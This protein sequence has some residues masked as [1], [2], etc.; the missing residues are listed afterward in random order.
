MESPRLT[1][2]FNENKIRT[3]EGGPITSQACLV[4]C[5]SASPEQNNECGCAGK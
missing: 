1:L 4:A 5:V 3:S 2:C